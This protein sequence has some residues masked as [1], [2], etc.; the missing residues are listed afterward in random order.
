MVGPTVGQSPSPV[1]TGDAP[2]PG[3]PVPLP[4]LL[5]EGSCDALG[6]L[7]QRLDDAS[8]VSR[9]AEGID[10]YTGTSHLEGAPE[11]A[12]EGRVLVAGGDGEAPESAVIC[13]T[14]GEILVGAAD[15]AIL[16]APL[17]DVPWWG[18]ALVG[19]GD[20]GTMLTIIVAGPFDGP[21]AGAS[22][23]APG[24]KPSASDPSPDPSAFVPH[25]S[26]L[27]GTSGA[28]PFS[29][30]PAGSPQP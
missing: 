1:A 12:L 11:V 22:A 3:V 20:A 15:Q 19:A 23:G 10:L 9:T 24:A 30:L 25:R 17:H 29:P 21:G 16:L 4:V 14:M 28:P 27:P 8:V 26:P 7:V 2:S 5:A 6:A 13:G 18:A